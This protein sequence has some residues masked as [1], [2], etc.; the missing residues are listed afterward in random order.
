MTPSRDASMSVLEYIPLVNALC[1]HQHTIREHAQRTATLAYALTRQLC[2]SEEETYLISLAA[3]VHDIGKIA[4]PATILN[5]PGPLSENEWAIVRCHPEIGSQLL[6]RAGGMW[7]SIASLVLAHHE[8]W[9]G[10]GYPYGLAKE[11][12]PLGA[13][14]L[15]IVDAYDAMTESRP[16]RRSLPPAEARAEVR[17]CAGSAYDPRIVDAFLQMEATDRLPWPW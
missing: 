1:W 12:I 14:I 6:Q 16:Y 4:V 15:A 5:K 7:T 17:R 2:L 9:D 8:R 10:R 11:A 3:L 13:R